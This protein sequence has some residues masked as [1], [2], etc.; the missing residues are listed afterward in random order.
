MAQIRIDNILVPVSMG[1]AILGG[2]ASII[3][4]AA[5]VQA[6]TD[7]IAEQIVTYRQNQADQERRLQELEKRWER[8]DV[9]LSQ[10]ADLLQVRVTTK[11]PP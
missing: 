7:W 2:A 1:L 4:C 6:R 8:I 5:R 9:R 10:I 11:G 3:W